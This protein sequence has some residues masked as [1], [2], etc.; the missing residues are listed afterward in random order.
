MHRVFPIKILF[1]DRYLTRTLSGPTVALLLVLASVLLLAFALV[2]ARSLW[3]LR[4]EPPRSP[5]GW[6][7]FH[8]VGVQTLFF[9]AWEPTSNE[10]WIWLLPCLAIFGMGPLLRGSPRGPRAA[11]AWA[12]PLALLLV[13]LPVVSRYWS[14]DNCI[15]RVNKTYLPRLDARDLPLT[16]A[17]YGITFLEHLEA[18]AIR[19]QGSFEGTFSLADT[20]LQRRLGEVRASGGRVVLDPMLVSPEDSENRLQ[21]FLAHCGR[22]STVRELLRLESFCA[23]NRIALLA[24]A[25]RGSSVLRF[26]PCPFA[27]YARW[28]DD[29][30]NPLPAGVNSAP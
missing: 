4:R 22:D 5:G 23:E 11:L 28:V 30:L 20:A 12:L 21:V 9:A 1:D 6:M 14:R 24:V 10:F 27:G 25:R 7:L 15:Y 16:R 19:P 18:P 8:W 29:R 3:L 13:N 26:E 17:A 2:L